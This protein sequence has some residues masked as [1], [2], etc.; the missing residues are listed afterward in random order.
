M[1]VLIIDNRCGFGQSHLIQDP[2][3][4]SYGK[5]YTSNGPFKAAITSVLHLSCS[6]LC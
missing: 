3:T 1:A 4:L 6:Y 2:N 5:P